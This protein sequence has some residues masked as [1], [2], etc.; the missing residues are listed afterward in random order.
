MG[1]TVT[2]VE[3]PTAD[4]RAFRYE[5]NRSVTGMAHV[6]FKSPES[7]TGHRPVDELARRLFDTGQVKAVH[8]YSN[9]VTVHIK[10]TGTAEGLGDVI[11]GLYTHYTEGVVPKKFD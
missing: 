10:F 4:A 9:H 3:K 2:V 11:R 5:L 8:M 1:Q 7:I 6:R